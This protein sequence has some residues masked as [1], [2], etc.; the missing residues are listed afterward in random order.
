MKLLGDKII[1]EFSNESVESIYMGKE[2]TR[3]DG[4]K[5]RLFIATP[6]D[7][8]SERK[9][10]LTIN[11]AFVKQV[12][13]DVKDVQVGDLAIVNYDLFN[14][15]NNLIENRGGEGISFWLNANTSYHDTTHVAYANKKSK[16]DQIVYERGDI[17]ESSFLLGIIRNE[18]LI[19]RS[20]IVFIDHTSNEVQKITGSGLIY[21]EKLKTFDRRVL[22][23]DEEAGKR[24]KIQEGDRILVADYDIFEIKMSHYGK[25]IDA[26]YERDI[27][28]KVVKGAKYPIPV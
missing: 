15:K 4:S 27:I 13:E 1:V 10:A 19:A 14:C 26:V 9:A 2:I 25:S 6:T 11:V 5:V 22:A 16:R 23:I 20:P 17:D 7:D 24:M 18:K 12:S 3:E 28:G 21:T 8:D